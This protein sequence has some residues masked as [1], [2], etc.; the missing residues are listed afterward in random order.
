MAF[1]EIIIALIVYAASGI[2]ASYY[3]FVV[4]RKDLLGG[5]WGGAVIGLVGAVLVTVITSQD[6]WFIRLISWLMIPRIGDFQ[7]PVNLIASVIGGL[8]F[9]AILNRINHSKDRRP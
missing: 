4:K 9:V 1:S 3:F 7:I 8:L 6:A 2:A 5:F